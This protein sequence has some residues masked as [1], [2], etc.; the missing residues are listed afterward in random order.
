MIKTY[1][2]NMLS[3]EKLILIRTASLSKL[4]NTLSSNSI[5]NTKYAKFFI[6][7]QVLLTVENLT[8]AYN[9]PYNLCQK[10]IPP[11]S[12]NFHL[13]IATLLVHKII[14]AIPTNTSFLYNSVIFCL[15]FCI[16]PSL[17]PFP[18]LQPFSLYRL[19]QGINEQGNLV[20][21]DTDLV[22]SFFLEVWTGKAGLTITDSL[23]V[24]PGKLFYCRQK[25]LMKLLAITIANHPIHFLP[26]PRL[27][28][29]TSIPY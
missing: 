11:F 26:Y 27:I 17:Q 10:S 2:S 18:L 9:H 6:K 5:F 23:F 20:R 13:P 4:D 7:Q 25:F 3:I 29:C 24:M 21:T 22:S 14:L 16:H 19:C 15:L 1:R 12:V 28:V 8:C